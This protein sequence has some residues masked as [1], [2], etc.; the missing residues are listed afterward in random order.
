MYIVL[1]NN[2]QLNVPKEIKQEVI[3]TNVTIDGQSAVPRRLDSI[4]NNAEK[5][6]IIND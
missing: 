6:P 5:H 4:D 1:N 2:A 3:D